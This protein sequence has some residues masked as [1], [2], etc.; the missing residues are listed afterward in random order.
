MIPLKEEHK[1]EFWI[2]LYLCIGALVGIP[3]GRLYWIDFR[4]SNHKA[5]I[6][7]PYKFANRI[8][9]SY[10]YMIAWFIYVFLYP[11]KL[12]ELLISKLKEK[13]QNAKLDK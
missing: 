4:S 6:V 9:D 11:L 8:V 7:Y 1:M 12:L 13:K 2:I 5:N 10:V 3:L